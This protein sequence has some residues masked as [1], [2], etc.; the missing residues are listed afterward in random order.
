MCLHAT[1][2]FIMHTF[3]DKG[4]CTRINEMMPRE[5]YGGIKGHLHVKGTHDLSLSQNN[6]GHLHHVAP[7]ITTLHSTHLHQG[8]PKYLT[9]CSLYILILLYIDE[10]PYARSI[11]FAANI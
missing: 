6:V 11:N 4:C 1:V 9:R 2:L 8:L 10:I 5:P 7:P 3:Y